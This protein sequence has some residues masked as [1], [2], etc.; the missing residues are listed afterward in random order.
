[1]YQQIERRPI[2]ARSA[3]W[4]LRAARALVKI[5]FTPNQVS[6]MSAVFAL[7][8]AALLVASAYLSGLAV[9]ASLVGA[10][11][12]MQ[13][14]LLCNLLDGMMAVECHKL[15]KKGDLFNELPDRISDVVLLV[16]AGYAARAGETGIVLGWLAAVLAVMTAY[17]R[18]FGSHYSKSQDYSGPMAKP[19]RMF[20]LTV[21]SLVT[22]AQYAYSH[23]VSA[24]LVTLI[25]ITGGAV[26]T[27]VRRT[28]RIA[29]AMEIGQ[30]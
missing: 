8:G 7:I 11:A 30:C 18:A 23:Q 24:I 26:I 12:C 20:A 29:E 25:V 13:L 21:G 9:I 16:G 14:R 28:A 27:C 17:L 19:H 22:C 6:V 15:S 5:G 3:G 10:A 2:K 1:M 4:T